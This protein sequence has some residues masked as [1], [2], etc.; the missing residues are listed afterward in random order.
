[1]QRNS[2]PISIY[3]FNR[4]TK[5]QFNSPKSELIQNRT[6]SLLASPEY[7][8]GII[9]MDRNTPYRNNKE[10]MDDSAVESLD[11]E[12]EELQIV[13]DLQQYEVPQPPVPIC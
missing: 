12:D 1:M 11:E 7:T 3:L 10:M 8:L 2:P 9:E 5:R 13:K 6:I 4:S